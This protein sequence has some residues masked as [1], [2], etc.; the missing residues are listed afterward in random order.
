MSVFITSAHSAQDL[1]PLLAERLS[2]PQADPFTPDVVVAPGQGMIDWLQENLSSCM[3]PHGII[4]NVHFWHPNE[5]NINATGQFAHSTTDAWDPSRLQWTLLEYLLTHPQHDIAPGFTEARRKLSFARRVAEMFS[6]Y[7]IHRPEMI[8]QWSESHDTDGQLP[9]NSEQMW[10]PRLW[11]SIRELLGESPPERSHKFRHEKSSV[12]PV[13]LNGRLSLF[14]LES[15]SRSKVDLLR[16]LGINKDIH[17][18]HLTPIEDIVQKMRTSDRV[19]SSLRRD[20]DLAREMSHPLLTSWSRSALESA[21]LIASAAKDTMFVQPTKQQNVLDSLQNNLS[22]DNYSQ[23]EESSKQLLSQC[24]GSIQIHRCHGATRQVEVLRDA[25]LHI[26][27]ADPSLT[28]RDILVICPDLERFSPIIEPVMSARMG[29]DGA[30]LRAAIVDRSNATT[31]PVSA[32]LDTILA[33][34]GGRCSSL[35]VLE[36][37][38][39]D[40]VRQKFDLDNDELSTIS[41]WTTALKVQWGVSSD[42][43]NKWGYPT[44]YEEGS[45]QWAIDRLVSGILIQSTETVETVPTLS[46]F[47]DISGS[48]IA[49]IGKLHA[50]HRELTSLQQAAATPHTLNDWA[51]IVSG[52]VDSF[53]STAKE[54]TDY[55][56]DIRAVI[57]DMQRNAED[58]PNAMFSSQELREYLSLMI[59]SLRGRPLKWADVVR[60]GSPSRFRG[61]PA[62]VTAILGFDEDAFRG[63][64]SG[65]DDIL[66]MEPRLGERD[67]RFDEKLGLLT[68]LHS[69]S[70]CLVITC[71]GHD[72]NDNSEIPMPVLL[73][74]LKDAV[75]HA[76]STIPVGHRSHKPLIINHSRQAADSVNVALVSEHSAK[77]VTDFVEGPWSFDPSVASVVELISSIEN[78]YDRESGQ[79]GTPVLPPLAQDEISR[80]IDLE[81]LIAS[82]R[83]PTDMF[84]S[85]RLGV[86]MPRDEVVTD[87]EVPLW[88]SPLEYGGLGRDILDSVTSG[89]SPQEWWSRRR[90][91]G[92]LPLGVAADAVLEKLLGEIDLLMTAA[93]PFIQI[94]TSQLNVALEHTQRLQQSNEFEMKVVVTGTIN[95]RNEYVVSLNFS[96]WHPRMRLQQWIYLAA[97]TLRDPSIQW[98]SV[99]IAR[100]DEKPSTSA[101]APVLPPTKVVQM[102]LQ[103][104]SPD[105]RRGNAQRIF[106]LA[107]NIRLTALRVPIPLFERSS[108][109][110]KRSKSELER[111]LSYDLD[112]P[113]HRLVYGNSS[114]NDLRAQ[115]LIDGVDIPTSGSSRFEMYAELLT[116]TWDETVTESGASRAKKTRGR[117]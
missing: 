66:A 30:R 44:E 55:I 74:E 84:V 48:D 31:S 115:P 52:V 51:S 10:Q 23:S 40:P 46:S 96:K 11:R 86:M 93:Q 79:F 19:I 54:W 7:A 32:A 8:I 36:A 6:R 15:F 34:A 106:A 3:G 99:I 1:I 88:P 83:R 47:D 70:D 114:V 69:T 71:D 12:H 21:T 60:V 72:V 28:P 94:P 103:G 43:R 67:S 110:I 105:D 101:S 39:I 57:G 107:H 78:E 65:S 77:N 108:W 97:L 56:L 35:E 76:I 14:G 45:W 82:L 37:L 59:P 38:S 87:P 73:E 27:A 22:T 53:L 42:H 100:N 113:S 2:A 92:G 68:T 61:V 20:M 63:S 50:F 5:F 13:L 33:L 75:T 80:E 89:T 95:V 90:L 111:E 9:L 26:L 85:Q 24:D 25:L 17:V 64:R 116:T 112:R 91:Q 62:R 98:Q 104:D 117:K 58:A 29:V 102:S 18:F 4:A 49:T 109:F 41:D 16:A 81:N